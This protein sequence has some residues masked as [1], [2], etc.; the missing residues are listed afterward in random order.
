MKRFV[1]IGECMME[2][3]PQGDLWQ[4][5]VAGDTFNTAWYARA[6]LGPDW[7]VGYQTALG[8][9]GFS[10]RV[11]DLMQAAGIRPLVTRH[12]SRSI[13][14]YAIHLHQGERS[15]SYWRSQSAARTLADDAA[16]LASG[17][18]GADAIHLSGITLAI[19]PPEGRDRLLGLLQAAPGQVVFDPNLRLK[20]W[21]DPQTA[22]EVM[23][24]AASIADIVLPS[25]DDEATLFGDATPK[26]TLDR[27]L[28]LGASE[29]LVKNGGGQILARV[30]A[31]SLALDLPRV[32]PLDTTGAGDSFNA[33]Y[34]AAR[35]AGQGAEAAIRAGHD[36]AA[37]VVRHA[38][39]LMPME[40]IRA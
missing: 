19:L 16:T 28:G 40:D 8:L 24:R 33:G 4:M 6:L 27:Y 31:E 10:D 26:V 37:R 1:A 2:L 30:G 25:F 11:L 14:L 22:R 36:L 18:A 23:T 39:A 15:F 35:L 38:G 3:S 34:L 29:V 32:T 20:L 17:L 5:N 7:E 13:G 12:P 21:E 9:D